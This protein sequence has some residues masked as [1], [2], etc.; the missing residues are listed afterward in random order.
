MLLCLVLDTDH[1]GRLSVYFNL[2]TVCNCIVGNTRRIVVHIHICT[3]SSG[4]GKNL[5]KIRGRLAREEERK[6]LGGWKERRQIGE[7]NYYNS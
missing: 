3:I 7:G 5:S 6:K 1:S 4:L 2:L